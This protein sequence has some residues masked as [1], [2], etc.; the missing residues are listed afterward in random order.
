MPTLGHCRIFMVMECMQVVCP[1]IC[2]IMSDEVSVSVTVT[3]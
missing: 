3:L 1:V 2:D